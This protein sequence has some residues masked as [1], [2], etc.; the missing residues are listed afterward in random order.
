[1]NRSHIESLGK[2]SQPQ[3]RRSVIDRE[4]ERLFRE[5]P[6]SEQG[7]DM[8]LS[9]ADAN[10]ELFARIRHSLQSRCKSDASANPGAI[11][12]ILTCFAFYVLGSEAESLCTDEC[13][14]CF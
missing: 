10:W 7:L 6:L 9:R 5:N 8:F 2:K 11:P 3:S 13:L 1:V 12:F 14:D 4:R